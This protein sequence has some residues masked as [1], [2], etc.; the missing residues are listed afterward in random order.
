MIIFITK[1][2][3][4]WDSSE[5]PTVNSIEPLLQF[6]RTEQVYGVDTETTGAWNMRNDLTSLQIMRND[7]I[8]LQVGNEEVQYVVDWQSMSTAERMEILNEMAKPRATKVLQNAKFDLKFFMQYGVYLLNIYDVMVA[9]CLIYAGR[10][11]E[12]GFFALDAIAARYSDMRLDKSVRGK[13]HIEG[14]TGRVIRYGAADVECLIPIMRGTHLKLQSLHMAKEDHQDPH[15]VLGIENRSC[16]A[17]AM[18]EFNGLKLDL[19]KWEQIKEELKESIIRIEKELDKIVVESDLFTGMGMRQLDLFSDTVETRINWGSWQQK[20]PLLKQINPEIQD[21]SERSLSVHKNEHPIIPKLIEYAKTT[22]LYN[23]FAKTMPKM[24]NPVTN[25]IHTS[26]WQN[27]ST[28]RVS[29]DSPN[30]QNIPARSEMGGRMR[31]CFIHEEGWKIVGGDYSG[32]ELRVMAEFSQD[33]LWLKVFNEDGDLHSELC[34]KTFNIP[35]SDVKTMSPYGVKYRDVQ[36]TINFGLAYGMS[37]YKLADTLQISIEEARTIINQFFAVVPTLKAFLNK[38]GRFAVRKGFSRTPPPYGRIR[39][40]DKYKGSPKQRG[41]VEREGKNHPI[42]GANADMVKLAL[43]NCYEYIV[44]HG[45][46]D[47]VKLMHT[48]H[49]EIQT[50][51]REDIA[52]IWAVELQNIMVEAASVIIKS[53]PMVVDVKIGDNWGETK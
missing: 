50:E 9:E 33:P 25:R 30:L 32:C 1:Q 46:T 40:F 5:I 51:A 28:G 2:L 16:L 47:H 26:F 31:E 42:Q 49:D 7:L 13:I 45:L 44:N 41:E 3:G 4:I 34:A 36:K 6:M 53:I 35:I 22:K 24:I 15:T 10:K 48:I 12:K 23:G 21:T 37:E 17:F 39:W 11:Q 14:L 52:E 8:S 38:L 27:Q 43:A 29:T 19:V 18:M 20:L